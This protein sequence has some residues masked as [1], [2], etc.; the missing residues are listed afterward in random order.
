M[1]GVLADCRTV[2]F[3]QHWLAYFS[4][5]P[6]EFTLVEICLSTDQNFMIQ[7]MI[8]PFFGKKKLNQL[9]Q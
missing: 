5:K 1:T 4:L 3:M 6:Y 7:Q 2:L 9:S 8:N